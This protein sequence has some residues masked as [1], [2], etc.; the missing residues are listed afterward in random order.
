MW[1][2]RL[3]SGPG[4]AGALAALGLPMAALALG[5]AAGFDPKLAIGAALGVVFVA[6]VMGE[7]AL[8]L[9]LF[10][11]LAFFE[12]L[13]AVAGGF[14]FAKIGG[15][16]LTIAW[17]ATIAT[18]PRTS[19]A[20]VADHPLATCMLLAFLAWLAMSAAWAE[21]P[22]AA[23]A[24]LPRYGPNVLLFLIVYTAVRDRRHVVWLLAAFVAGATIAAL[25]GIARPPSQTSLRGDRI[26]GI[27]GDPNEL[28][29]VLI[30]GLVL[31]VALA[32]TLRR[33]TIGRALVPACGLVLL[34]GIFLTLS[35]GGLLALVVVTIVAVLNAGRWRGAAI[36]LAVL[37]VAGA[38]GYF[39]AFASPVARQR[40]TTAGSGS[41][42]TGLWTVGWRMVEAH[43]VHGIGAGN[44]AVSS[45]H[46]LL[47][48]GTIPNDYLVV[49]IPQVA[50]NVYLQL[51]AETGVVGLALF[52]G[53][54]AF[55]L[56]GAARAAAAFR[57][58]GDPRME[59]V[60]R[61]VFV[62]Q[63]GILA[64]DF[65]IS[66]QY[67]KQLWIILAFGPALLALAREAPAPG[68]G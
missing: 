13:P 43:P 67:N 37:A 53:I 68:A 14:T 22:G 42:R 40:V 51:L 15:I 30:V 44:F 66:A 23:L 4:T 16:L 61:S 54:V 60:A 28:A 8:G 25:Y 10:T 7:L 6:A 58:R 3:R 12:V 65:F 21:D 33:R 39:S 62:A 20:F 35:R 36:V 47:R 18:R 19:R 9:A 57:R 59:L 32:A 26:G 63:A 52:L 2:P 38:V 48:P 56:T 49:D 34:L 24:T 64:A 45:V 41:G 46:Y 29:S 55:A 11:V 31:A 1:Q 17:L 27:V 50:H 5:V